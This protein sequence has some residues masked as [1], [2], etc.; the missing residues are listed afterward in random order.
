MQVQELKIYWKFSEIS[1]VRKPG[2]LSF[3][4]SNEIYLKSRSDI[5]V[6]NVHTYTHTHSHSGLYMS[7]TH[8][9]IQ[10]TFT[11]IDNFDNI[12]ELLRKLWMTN[13]GDAAA[14]QSNLRPTSSPSKAGATVQRSPSQNGVM[15]RSPTTTTTIT[16]TTTPT[17]TT[18]DMR[19]KAASFAGNSSLSKAVQQV[20]QQSLQQ[21]EKQ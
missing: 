3:F 5:K 17:A 15:S 10:F 21:Q 14:I 9:L 11:N 20:K 19:A 7:L 13:D 4:K 12:Y 16:T 6:L 18:A 8:T 1:S 2:I